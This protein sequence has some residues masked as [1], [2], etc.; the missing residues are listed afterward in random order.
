MIRPWASSV[1]SL[2]VSSRMKAAF[3]DFATLGPGVNTHALDEL[4]EVSYYTRSHHAEILERLQGTEVALLNKSVLD[5]EILAAST[6]LKLIVLAATGTDNVDLRVAEQRGIAVANIRDY[7]TSAVVQHVMALMLGLTRQIG[8]YRDIV[9]R[10]AW[11]QSETFALFDY[12]IRELTGKVLGIAGYGVLGR[13]VADAGRCMGM[14]VLIAERLDVGE[15]SIREGRVPLREVLENADVLSLHCPLTAANRH[16]IGVEELKLMKPDSLLINTARGAL[17]DSQALVDALKAGVIAGAGID[18]LVQEPPPDD[19]PL[20][21]S[22]IPNLLLTPHIAWSAKESRQRALD[23]MVENIG[24]YLNGG[25][26][27][28]VV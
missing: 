12:P 2:V 27:R 3:L 5:Q 15:A 25:Q 18:V 26:L 17:I 6:A 19:E 21:G 13:A 8:G 22:D 11:Q 20:L 9:S 4:L 24:D 1:S 7:C 23:Q 28:R 14:E 16:M 10:G